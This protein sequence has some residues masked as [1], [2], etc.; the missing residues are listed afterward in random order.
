MALGRIHRL[1]TPK[2]INYGLLEGYPRF[3]GSYSGT[4]ATEQIIVASK[5]IGM[6]IREF[7]PPPVVDSNGIVEFEGDRRYLPRH[8][9]FLATSWS[10][11]PFIGD[12][13]D[14][15]FFA[16][17]DATF[18][19]H[20]RIMKVTLNYEA[21]VQDR[22]EGS[23]SSE[24]VPN[25]LGAFP[26]T[27]VERRISSGGEFLSI[28]PSKTKVSTGSVGDNQQQGTPEANQD[29]LQPVVKV[30]PNIDISLRWSY[31]PDPDWDL[32]TSALGSIND[33][34][35]QFLFNLPVETVLFIGFEARPNYA[36]M[37]DELGRGD[38]DYYGDTR[39]ELWD[40]DYKLVGRHIRDFDAGGVLKSYG[41]NHVW[42]PNKQEWV[43][44]KRGDGA[45]NLYNQA[46]LLAALFIARKPD[47]R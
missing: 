9:A 17:T 24:S 5:E 37:G 3:S 40:I 16:D 35:E 2:G 47:A 43:R 30:I 31:N 36:W 4:K 15:P 39:F 6:L 14:D 18:E 13:P 22:G 21:H 29:K 38:P 45:S 28:N 11:E 12:L 20:G 46:D 41:W 10:A 44:V 34:K 25:L 1:Q 23:A 7:F 27:F 8:R 26:E 42:S 32:M 19:T 33:S